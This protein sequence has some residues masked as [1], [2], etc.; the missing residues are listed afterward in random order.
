MKV[1]LAVLLIAASLF[2]AKK[3]PEAS[4][5]KVFIESAASGIDTYIA[6]AL[7][8]KNV[9]V[10]VVTD[11]EMADFVITVTSESQKAGW[12]KILLAGDLRSSEDVSIRMA[13]VKSK[14]VAF[15]YSYHMGSSYHGKQSAAESCAKH[16][17]QWLKER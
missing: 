15:A 12:A 7:Q 17:G 11:K 5:P 6:A 14:T 3:T 4:G 16:L 1:I 8:K 13:D 10:I 9:P 2:A